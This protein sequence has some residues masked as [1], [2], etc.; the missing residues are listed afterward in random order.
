MHFFLP[1]VPKGHDRCSQHAWPRSS[2]PKSGSR[3][4]S[5]SSQHTYSISGTQ[6]CKVEPGAI[7]KRSTSMQRI[8]PAQNN[9][10]EVLRPKRKNYVCGNEIIN[11]RPKHQQ[12]A[13]QDTARTPSSSQSTRDWSY[14]SFLPAPGW[15][16][17]PDP[18]LNSFIR[19]D[20]ALQ[21]KAMLVR[22]AYHES[23]PADSL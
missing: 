1:L 18:K 10:P 9:S 5:P 23:V 12:R 17:I 8:L 13:N 2:G 4:A 7:P 16:I 20:E 15:Q 19:S 22:K 11:N 14:A 21:T 3:E 6:S